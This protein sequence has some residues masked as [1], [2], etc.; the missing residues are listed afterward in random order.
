MKKILLITFALIST[1]SHS[2]E[3]DF[4]KPNYKKIKKNIKKKNSNLYYNSLMTRFRNADSTMNLKEKR[5]LYYG[6]TFNKDYAP[7]SGSDYRDSIKPLMDKEKLDSL[8]LTKCIEFADAMLLHNPF[9]LNAMNYKSYALEQMGN[10]TDYKKLYHQ[11]IT[12][13]D[14][15]F[16][17]GNGKSRKEAFYVIEISHE[18]KVLNVLGFQWGGSQSKIESYDYLTLAENEWEI[19]GL[20]FDVSPALSVLSDMFD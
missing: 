13:Y 20:Y 1:L 17:S 3:R 14:A 4:E 5:H 16:S 6:Y 7:Y 19:E 15:I 8:D 12:I 11:A 18:Y 9:D 2:Q 10:I